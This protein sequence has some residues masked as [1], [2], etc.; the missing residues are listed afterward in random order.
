MGLESAAAR[1]ELKEAPHDMRITIAVGER[2]WAEQKRVS[3]ELQPVAVEWG[4][5][6][7][8]QRERGLAHGEMAYVLSKVDETNKESRSYGPCTGLAVVGQNK[9]GRPI[10][11]LSHQTP[12]TI[13]AESRF[14]EQFTHDLDEH[15][16]ALKEACKEGTIDVVIVG[17]STTEYRSLFGKKKISDATYGRVA[18]SL[19]DT[20]RK[21]LMVEPRVFGPTVNSAESTGITDVILD[22]QN[23]RLY[24]W[25][26][27]GQAFGDFDK[28]AGEIL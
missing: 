6:P 10:S 12:H 19:T 1:G 13:D 5:P 28:P 3:E 11:F 7:E 16:H 26:T 9:E 2:N 27:Q 24:I 4:I 8:I 23:R 21:I 18:H 22:T 25:R 14:S 15:L 17:G 20:V